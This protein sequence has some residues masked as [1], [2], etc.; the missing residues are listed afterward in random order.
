MFARASTIMGKPERIEDGIRD[1]KEQTIP[2]LRKITGFK[3]A[4]F[5]VD[6]KSG[7]M[8]SITFWDSEKDLQASTAAANKLRAQGAQGSGTTQPPAVDIYEVAVQS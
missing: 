2:T 3:Q 7:K 4:L 5:M 8:V 6:R 1:Y